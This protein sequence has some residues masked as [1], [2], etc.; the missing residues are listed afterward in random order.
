MK[1]LS[2]IFR[3]CVSELYEE[4][5]QL[6]KEIEILNEGSLERDIEKDEQDKKIKY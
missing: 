4:N 3:E 1:L 5:I 2:R 6:H